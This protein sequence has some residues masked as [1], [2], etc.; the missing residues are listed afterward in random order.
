M[1]ARNEYQRIAE[2]Y[3]KVLSEGAP[4]GAAKHLRAGAAQGA[5]AVDSTRLPFKLSDVNSNAAKKVATSGQEDHDLED[6][7]ISVE[8]DSAIA[9]VSQLNP[10]QS[11]MNI[12]KALGMVIGMLDPTSD[13]LNAGGDLDAFITK[14]NYIMDGHHRWIAT[15]M[16]DP[17]LSVGG[18][19]VDFPAQQLIAILNTMTKGRYGIEQGNPATGGFKEFSNDKIK[20]QLVEFWQNGTEYVKPEDVQTII[21]NWTGVEGEGAIDAAV[22]KMV[23]NLSNVTMSVPEWAPDREDM[24]VIDD[25]KFPG[26][27]KDAVQAL[28]QGKV[29]WNDPTADVRVPLGPAV[30]KESRLRAKD[31]FNLLAESYKK[32]LSE[33]PGQLPGLAAAFKASQEAPGP[34]VDFSRTDADIDLEDETAGEEGYDPA[35]KEA[36]YGKML[37]LLNAL[38]GLKTDYADH[39]D[40]T[41][42]FFAMID[43]ITGIAGTEG[44]EEDDDTEEEPTSVRV[45]QGRG[46]TAAQ[47]KAVEDTDQ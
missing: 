12:N 39:I 22:A 16:I 28:Q 44:E 33:G 24:P 36:A 17:S 23:S 19:E 29:D 32:V 21:Q 4:V 3:N 15:A 2:S 41:D 37:D 26:A 30:K 35:Y 31:E 18:Y 46:T 27:V 9:P 42:D 34:V 6:D 7:K 20:K 40:P 10:S 43:K 38:E 1:R 5:A 11:S 25:D 8:K 14:D 13:K 45:N 47:F